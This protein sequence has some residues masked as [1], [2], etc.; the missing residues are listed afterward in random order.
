MAAETET[1]HEY[2]HL[3]ENRGNLFTAAAEGDTARVR[4]ILEQRLVVPD[5]PNEYGFTALHNA[6][7]A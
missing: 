6:A 2:S 7:R 1:M 5:K 4:E 3:A